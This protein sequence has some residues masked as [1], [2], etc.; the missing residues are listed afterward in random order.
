MVSR[1]R[2]GEDHRGR[3]SGKKARVHSPTLFLPRS[4]LAGFPTSA[5]GAR[6]RTW[7]VCVNGRQI[8]RHRARRAVGLNASGFPGRLGSGKKARHRKPLS[9]RKSRSFS[10]S[11]TILS[12]CFAAAST[13]T[14]AVGSG[15]GRAPEMANL[16]DLVLRLRDVEGTLCFRANDRDGVPRYSDHAR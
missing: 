4:K 11:P 8:G 10:V 9:S 5:F 6:T 7:S 16:Q 13:T 2:P 15:H 14:R 3:R 12:I 1:V